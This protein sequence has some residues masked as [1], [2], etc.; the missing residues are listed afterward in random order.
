[1]KKPKDNTIQKLMDLGL[2]KPLA[3]TAF[4]RY[5]SEALKEVQLD[6]YRLLRYDNRESWLEID[7]LAAKF[8]FDESSQE[9][10]YGA[11]CFCLGLATSEG[12]VF[13]PQIDLL[14]RTS[15]L[16]G[17]EDEEAYFRNLEFLLEKKYLRSS[18]PANQQ[19]RPIYLDS[20]YRAEGNTAYFLCQL[21]IA[22]SR[23]AL[24]KPSEKE[25]D[26]VEKDMEISLAPAQR[27][28]I[29]SSLSNKIV[30]ITGG[31]GTGKTTIIKGVLKLWHKKKAKILLAAPTGR[32][33]KRLA[34]STGKTA[35]TIH[36]ML[37]YTPNESFNRNASNKLDVDLL[38]VDESSMIDIEL[39]SS[40][41]ESLPDTC[42]LVF[43]GDVDQ[44]PAVG[45]GNVLRDMI[46]S[47][48]FK[49]I[50]LTDIYRQAQ[51][52]LISLNAKKIN[53]GED[54]DLNGLGVEQGQDFFFIERPGS[55]KV[56][57]AI[58]EMALERIPRQF[59]LNPKEDIQILCPMIKKDLGVEKMNELLQDK[60]TPCTHRFN[61]SSYSFSIGDKVMQTKN[62][63][64][65]EVFNGDV[66]YVTNII[67]KELVAVISFDGREVPYSRN[68]LE[69]T[70]LAYAVTVHKSQGSEYPAV[71]VP[72][73][74]QHYPMLYRNLLYTAVSRG[75]R[76][77]VLVG[78]LEALKIA[79][80]NN[81]IS[82]R[83]TGLKDV[84]LRV[85]AKAE[86]H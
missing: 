78:S 32:A 2:S 34:E 5:G 6:P 25:L 21:A 22:S 62:D 16:L 54:P 43:V 45:P 58:L 33:A 42:H 4:H 28:A 30:I 57:E 24:K 49:T 20:L 11:F 36:R 71:I 10:F 27:E 18:F 40:L 70:S 38:V 66:G 46:E 59:G 73:T 75:K 44:L 77:V 60:L 7:H 17:V 14:K 53:L 3:F 19:N 48:L 68:D 56:Q 76:L 61:A 1:M 51:G 26:S 39:M 83:F 72:L 37:E 86:P 23:I 79:V 65:K 52:S 47:N 81:R 67:P 31:P 35:K 74:R 63:Y 41:L 85:F 80:R 64:D 9:R 8:G 69:N 15:A 82:K 13:L 29:A 50:S 55:D 12:H 84:L